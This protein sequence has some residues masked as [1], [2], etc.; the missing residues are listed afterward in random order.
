ML[1]LAIS[2]PVTDDGKEIVKVLYI[3]YLLQFQGQEG[4]EQIKALLDSGNKVN[5][6]NLAF[7]QKL[8]LHI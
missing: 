5:V 3:Y 1:V 7:A 6:M 8:G 4:Q 2:V